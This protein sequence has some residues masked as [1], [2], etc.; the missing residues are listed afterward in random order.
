MHQS[1]SDCWF[2]DTKQDSWRKE[3]STAAG[4]ERKAA[5]G[6]CPSV[7]LGLCGLSQASLSLLSLYVLSR[8]VVFLPLFSTNLLWTSWPTPAP[9]FSKQ[10]LAAMNRDRSSL[11]ESLSDA[12]VLV[13]PGL[14]SNTELFACFPPRWGMWKLMSFLALSPRA[15]CEHLVSQKS[16]S[17][18]EWMT[19]F[20]IVSKW[21]NHQFSIF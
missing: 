14:C 4:V 1:D 19:S 2:S 6:G 11:S 10:L 9:F 15:W 16:S 20:F 12:S 7:H 18:P 13:I 5:C 8:Q 3:N 21:L 17:S